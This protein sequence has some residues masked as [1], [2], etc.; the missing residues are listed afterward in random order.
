MQAIPK[1]LLRYFFDRSDSKVLSACSGKWRTLSEERYVTR[2]VNRLTT[3]TKRGG[4]RVSYLPDGHL[5]GRWVSEHDDGY[6]S[7][8]YLRG[9]L[10]GI[11]LETSSERELLHS[12]VWV[13]G[14]AEGDVFFRDIHE[15]RLIVT[16]T[17]REG[18]LVSGDNTWREWYDYTGRPIKYVVPR[19]LDFM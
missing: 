17:Y 9:Y 15:N 4:H 8:G 7:I 10:H 11:C 5:H 6:T 2:S 12:A 3:T 16:D 14:L 18:Q 13:N 1:D 19:Y